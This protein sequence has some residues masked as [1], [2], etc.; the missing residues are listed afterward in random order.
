MIWH[1]LIAPK[2]SAITRDSVVLVLADGRELEVLR[3][4]NP[5]ARRIRLSVDERGARLTLPTRASLASG[6][7]FLHDHRDWLAMQLD[8]FAHPAELPVLVRDQTASLPLRG[9]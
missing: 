4:R 2:P 8:R 7:R 9:R 5:R 6:D 1:R 3:V